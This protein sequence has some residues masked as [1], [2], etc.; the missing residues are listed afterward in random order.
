MTVVRA[1]WRA[2]LCAIL[3]FAAGTRAD[4]VLLVVDSTGDEPDVTPGDGVCDNGAGACTLRAAI[5]EVNATFGFDQIHF[6]LGVGF[7]PTAPVTIAPATA[8]PDLSE[9][10]GVTIDGTTQPGYTG[11]PVVELDGSAVTAGP[12]LRITGGH[13]TIKGLSIHSF[14]SH[15]VIIR[16]SH[17]NS[18]VGNHIGVD[19]SGTIAK[20]NGIYGVFI[21]DTNDNFVGGPSPA[22]RNI[23]SGNGSDGV[24]LSGASAIGNLIAGN[25][26]GTDITGRVALGNGIAGV[27]IDEAPDNRVG[28]A[29]VGDGNL[30][31]GN[32]LYGVAI[33]GV[34]SIRNDV[35]GN[36]IGVDAAGGGAMGNLRGIYIDGAGSNRIGGSG[37]AGNVVSLNLDSGILIERPESISTLVRGNTIS[38]NG[39]D[40]VRI[41]IDASAS[42]IGTPAAGEG[43]IIAN[44][45]RHGVAVESGLGHRVSGNSIHDNG[46]LG[47][48]LGGD[49]LPAVNDAGDLDAG[50]NGL[51]NHPVL[52]TAEANCA[53]TLIS[54]SLDTVADQ[55]Y[56]IELYASPGCDSSGHGEG[57][58]F[59]G[60]SST[61]S[62][63]AGHVDFSIDVPL[64]LTTGWVVTATAS[65]T[66]ARSG[67]ET[68][69]FAACIPV[70]DLCGGCAATSIVAIAQLKAVRQGSN[71][72]L[73]WSGDP[74][75]GDGYNVEFVTTKASIPACASCLGSLDV[76]G[77]VPTGTSAMTTCVH[78][79]GATDPLAST[80]F[81]NVIGVCGGVEG[82]L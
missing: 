61:L 76:P 77:C 1:S 65:R 68:S 7:T 37:R 60:A 56:D 18:I 29:G 34:G 75:A 6:N 72:E 47:I 80:F 31:S 33:R 17:L 8:L 48:D 79:G 66:A 10:F 62:D 46:G 26:I 53:S 9:Y 32:G 82:P 69:E 50:A 5:E 58:Q 81:Y 67:G 15:G 30:I 21:I 73:T 44:N 43:N 27:T 23:I 12:G 54:G 59:L 25:Y 38:A 41:G 64:K 63:T 28:G 19:P 71:I 40:G 39:S 4:A 57:E 2:L 42:V 36:R 20:G 49:D 70:T 52:L 22:D 13:S 45:G 14:G 35:L 74:E 24:Q 16:G 78:L 11:T 51:Q 3:L 55:L